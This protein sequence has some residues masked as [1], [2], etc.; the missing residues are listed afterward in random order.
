VGVAVDR[1]TVL[2]RAPLPLVAGEPREALDARLHELERR[3]VRT[4][5][6]RW[7]W[8]RRDPPG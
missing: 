2:A 5:I 8:E 4:A 1:G 6:R 3:V 7:A